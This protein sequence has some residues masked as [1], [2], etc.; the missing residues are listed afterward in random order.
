MYY[1]SALIHY[2]TENENEK[3]NMQLRCKTKNLRFM[4]NIMQLN[5]TNC[6]MQNHYLKLC[7]ELV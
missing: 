4:M 2:A 5:Y 6:I 3:N 1:F 7:L